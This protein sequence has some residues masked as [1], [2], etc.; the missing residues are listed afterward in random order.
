MQMDALRARQALARGM[1]ENAQRRR[2]NSEGCKRRQGDDEQAFEEYLQRQAQSTRAECG[3]HGKLTA[4]RGV[5]GEQQVGRVGD[6]DQQQ[7]GRAEGEQEQAAAHRCGNR[8]GQRS[9]LEIR[10]IGLAAMRRLEARGECACR[11]SRLIEIFGATEAAEHAPVMRRA[12][13]A[14]V[15]AI[16]NPDFGAFGKRKIRGHHRRHRIAHA[17]DD[18]ALAKHIG[19]A[20][21]QRLPQSMADDRKRLAI[22]AGVGAAQRRRAAEHLEESPG[23]QGNAAAHAAVANLHGAGTATVDCHRIELADGGGQIGVVWAGHVHRMTFIGQFTDLHEAIGIGIRQ[24]AQHHRIDHAVDGDCRRHAEGQRSG[25]KH[26]QTHARAQGAQ[27][28]TQISKHGSL[29]YS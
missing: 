22:L 14:D 11:K 10:R 29:P 5:Q 28:K 19:P 26:G 21:E 7:E 1:D 4:A 12:R 13:A 25:G 20:L 27:G 23:G 15:V 24:A 3:T 8:L 16:G 9:Q 2:G 6:R 18:D 17:I